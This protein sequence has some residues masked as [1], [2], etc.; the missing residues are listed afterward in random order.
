MKEIAK[1][2]CERLNE[3]NRGLKFKYRYCWRSL[4]ELRLV[5]AVYKTDGSLFAG[6]KK[7]N[8]LVEIKEG[9][10]NHKNGEVLVIDSRRFSEIDDAVEKVNK[11]LEINYEVYEHKESGSFYIG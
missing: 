6:L 8:K 2:I 7:A 9:R 10:N 11:E 3:N 5:E 4:L 1:S